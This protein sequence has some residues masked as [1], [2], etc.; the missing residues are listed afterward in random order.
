MDVIR[1][2]ILVQAATLK[3][4]HNETA[5]LDSQPSDGIS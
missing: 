1:Y 5:I 4:P 3:L 2:K